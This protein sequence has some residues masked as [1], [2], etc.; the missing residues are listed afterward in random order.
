M[1]QSPSAELMNTILNDIDRAIEAGRSVYLHCRGGVGR[2]GT[3]VGCFLMR[4]GLAGA[5]NVLD[6]IAWMRGSGGAGQECSPETEAQRSFVRN[7]LG[8]EQW[9][10]SRGRR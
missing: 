4:H 6:T 1:L 10:R 9:I 5:D 7:W 8:F 3:V 2:T